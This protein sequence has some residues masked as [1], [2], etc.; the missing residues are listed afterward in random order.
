MTYT[1]YV[2]FQYVVTECLCVQR[3]R[4]NGILEACRVMLI[5]NVQGQ[6]V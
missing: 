4:V 1:D 6:M 5:F 2:F 3:G